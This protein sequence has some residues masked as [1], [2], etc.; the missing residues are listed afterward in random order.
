[1]SGI[2]LWRVS[3]QAPSRITP[4]EI[5]LERDL[6]TWI[7]HDPSLLEHGLTIIGRQIRLDGG[8]LDLLAIDQQGRFVL[9]EIKRDRLRR[10][11][12]VQ[13]ID[14]ASSLERMSAD[15]LRRCCSGYLQQKSAKSLDELLHERGTSLDENDDGL[16]VV[17]YLVGTGV[18]AHLDRMV[19]YLSDRA[20]LAI[21]VVT[22]SVFSDGAGGAILAREIHEQVDTPRLNS[23][24]TTGRRPAPVAD[25]LLAKADRLGLGDIV[26]PIYEASVEVGLYA[27][28][29]SKS[30]KIAPPQNRSYCLIYVPIDRPEHIHEGTLG[31]WIATDAFAHFFNITERELA[32]A[33]GGVGRVYANADTARRIASGLRE[34]LGTL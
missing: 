1:M 19:S 28:P 25:E 3:N 6:E 4:S 2:G 30:F 8:P 24:S 21:R 7:E 17:I 20:E 22:F 33:L 23:S 10:D 34:L 32:D 18:D 9:I 11:V 26:R 14:Y 31:L 5:G 29:H 15:D 27:Q 12:V 16:G 13:A